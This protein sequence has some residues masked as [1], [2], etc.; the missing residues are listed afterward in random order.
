MYGGVAAETAAT[1]AAVAATSGQIVT[2]D[3]RPAVTYFFASSGGYTEDIQNVWTGAT[4]EPWLR[5]VP[6]PYDGAGGDP[7]HRWSYEMSVAA[8]GRKLGSLV[9]GRLLGIVV[10]RHGVSPR[11][12]E[13]AVV[14]TR[15]RTSVSGTALQGIFGLPTTYATFTAISTSVGRNPQRHVYPARQGSAVWVQVAG[16]KGWHTIERGS[17]GPGA[18]T[19]P[20]F[21]APAPIGFSPAV[22]RPASPPVRPG[23]AAGRPATGSGPTASSPASDGSAGAPAA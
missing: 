4:P 9:K 19:T 12:L 20:P 3:G 2:Y 22:S 8:A 16:R 1:D 21:P 14:G 15:G 11:I 5:G 18:P 6:D 13:A 23:A 7:Y 10:T 17:I